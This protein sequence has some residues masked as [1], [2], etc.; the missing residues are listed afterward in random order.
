MG[1][2]FGERRNASFIL[3]A[4]TPATEIFYAATIE[5]GLSKRYLKNQRETMEKIALLKDKDNKNKFLQLILTGGET[6][7]LKT[8]NYFLLIHTPSGETGDG[9]YILAFNFPEMIGEGAHYQIFPSDAENGNAIALFWLLKDFIPQEKG[10][11][12][13]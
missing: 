11:T 5:S 8:E 3:L 6:L 10:E 2:K 12:M 13:A 1:K 7:N 4:Q 9:D